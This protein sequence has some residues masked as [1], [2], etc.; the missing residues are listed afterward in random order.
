MCI[1]KFLNG[2]VMTRLDVLLSLIILLMCSCNKR[3]TTVVNEPPQALESQPAPKVEPNPYP[4]EPSA[5]KGQETPVDEKL[6]SAYN[7]C[8]FKSVHNAYERKETLEDQ[9]D[10]LKLRSIELDIHPTRKGEPV[11]PGD[12]YVYHQDN[13]KSS[14]KLLSEALTIIKKNADTKGEMITVWIDLKDQLKPDYDGDALDALLKKQL[15][16]AIFAPK[17][18]LGTC[19]GATDF[20]NFAEACTWPTRDVLKGRVLIALTGKSAKP[21]A[22][23][24]REAVDRVGFL[25]PEI[26]KE[27]QLAEFSH[28]MIFNLSKDTVLKTDLASA[29]FAQNKLSRTWDVNS[30]DDWRK[31]TAKPVNHIATDKVDIQKDP[32]ASTQSSDGGPCSP[33][34]P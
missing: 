30:E 3:T 18:L 31:I 15:G 21:Y 9:L 25:T 11:L 19:K 12:W 29:V 8:Q 2:Q 20:K 1:P 14:I 34:A 6:G 4:P 24:M 33:I 16:S 27:S 32:W 23:T 22:T 13:S 17:D 5:E 28:A 26:S 10:V 7:H